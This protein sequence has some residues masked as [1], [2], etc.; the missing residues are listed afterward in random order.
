[1]AGP[2]N[3]G[4]IDTE[5]PEEEGEGIALLLASGIEGPA[6]CLASDTDSRCQGAHESAVQLSHLAFAGAGRSG[7]PVFFLWCLARIELLLSNAF[8]LARLPPACSFG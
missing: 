2:R 5:G 4:S 8:C 6:S 7:A 1:M 3:P